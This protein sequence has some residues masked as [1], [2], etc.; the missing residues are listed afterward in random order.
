MNNFYAKFGNI[1]ENQRAHIRLMRDTRHAIK[2]KKKVVRRIVKKTPSKKDLAK[3]FL[4][5]MIE[6]KVKRADDIGVEGHPDGWGKL[7][8]PHVARQ[9][10]HSRL[11]VRGDLLKFE[12]TGDIWNVIRIEKK[13]DSLEYIFELSHSCSNNEYHQFYSKDLN[14]FVNYVMEFRDNYSFDKYDSEFNLKSFIRSPGEMAFDEIFLKCVGDCCV[15]FDPTKSKTNCCKQYYCKVC[16]T[17]N[18]EESRCPMCRC[19]FPFGEE[20]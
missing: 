12:G 16:F 14:V 11:F 17:L 6:K 4:K 10:A 7:Y 1:C 13:R 9:E 18:G 19:E 2:R 8:H 20:E 5:E 3:Q 15:C